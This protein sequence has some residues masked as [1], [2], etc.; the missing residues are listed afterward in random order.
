MIFMYCLIYSLGSAAQDSAEDTKRVRINGHVVTAIISEGDTII[1]A[2]L[3]SISVSS[4]HDFGSK[5]EY[6]RYLKYR[7]YANKVYPYAVETIK[8]YRQLEYDTQDMSKRKRRK[9]ARKLN[10]KLKK[11]FKGELKKLSKTQG[12]ILTKMI[13]RHLD[14]SVHQLVKENRGGLHAS[15]WQNM[16]KFAGYNLKNKYQKGEDRIMDIVLQDFDISY[17][18]TAPSVDN[19]AK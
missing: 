2:D 1:V 6:R 17:E 8:M 19:D 15:Y 12:L 5:D 7:R 9:H 10:R 18:I 16:G 11:Q 3:E 14:K 4:I 13:E